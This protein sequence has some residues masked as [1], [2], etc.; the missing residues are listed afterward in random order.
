MDVI[1][2]PAP[3]FNIN[4]VSL[5]RLTWNTKIMCQTDRFLPVELQQ[6][7]GTRTFIYVNWTK[8]NSHHTL[9]VVRNAFL[10]KAKAKKELMLKNP[11]W[12]TDMAYFVIFRRNI[13][14]PRNPMQKTARCCL[15][16]EYYSANCL[17]Q[18]L[19]DPYRNNLLGST[20]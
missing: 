4:S 13:A 17:R 14:L 7:N 12:L 2:Y 1:T 18:I 11:H 10:R 8:T 6:H 9:E 5:C 15:F 19:G 16:D 20:S 3:Q